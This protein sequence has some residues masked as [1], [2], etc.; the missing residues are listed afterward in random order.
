MQITFLFEPSRSVSVPFAAGPERYQRFADEL[1][2][3][4]GTKVQIARDFL[5]K[6]PRDGFV[7]LASHG[8]GI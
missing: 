4:A 3:Y 6:A 1:G 8:G 2:K 7:L 5:R